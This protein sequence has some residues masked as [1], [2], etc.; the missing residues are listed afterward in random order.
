MTSYILQR[1]M[2]AITMVDS[3]RITITISRKTHDE[4]DGIGKR[5]ESFDDIIKKCIAAYKKQEQR[6]ERQAK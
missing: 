3:N 2:S 5:G 6:G 4:L 1:C